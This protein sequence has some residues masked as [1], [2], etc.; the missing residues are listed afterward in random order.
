MK[1][2]SL[3]FLDIVLHSSYN[4]LG[5]TMSATDRRD[6]ELERLIEV[7]KYQSDAV[8]INKPALMELALSAYKLG[9]NQGW[10]Y[11]QEIRNELKESL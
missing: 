8:H 3:T 6:Q 10:A 11:E 1:H 2:I 7:Y 9:L 5:E 4:T